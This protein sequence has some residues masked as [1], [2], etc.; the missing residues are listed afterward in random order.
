[1]EKTEKYWNLQKNFLLSMTRNLTKL[2][3]VYF[4]SAFFQNKKVKICYYH[5]YNFMTKRVF[6]KC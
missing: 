5:E 4:Y 1:M 6:C 3:E 2:A